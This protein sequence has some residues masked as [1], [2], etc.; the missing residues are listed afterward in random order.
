MREATHGKMTLPPSFGA[1]CVNGFT[2]SR[3][4]LRQNSDAQPPRS[5][6]MALTRLRVLPALAV[7]IA[8]A[9]VALAANRLGATSRDARPQAA[10][11]A[12]VGTASGTSATLPK[13]RIRYQATIENWRRYRSATTAEAR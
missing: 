13:E 9:L 12:T 10:L 7:A 4:V 3:E 1:S 11:Q 2:A 5:R 6:E 8:L